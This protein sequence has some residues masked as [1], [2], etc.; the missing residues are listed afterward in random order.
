MHYLH[1]RFHAMGSPCS[2][3]LYAHDQ[4][5]ALATAHLVENEVLRL[6]HKYSRYRDD[7]VTAAL[8]VA[9]R[10]GRALA[11]DSETAALLDYAQVAWE[12]SDGLFDITSGVLRHAWSFPHGSVPTQARLDELLARVGWQH[13][14]WQQGEV[15][16]DRPGMEIDFGGFVKEYAADCAAAVAL[17]AGLQHGLVELGGD[18]R[19]IGPHPDGRPWSVGIRHPRLPGQVLATI[20]LQRG[21][22]ASSGDYERCLIHNGVRYGHILNPFTGW[23][24]QGLIAVS[25]VADHCLLAGSVATLAL[26]HGEQGLAWLE[27]GEQPWLAMTACGAVHGSLAPSVGLPGVR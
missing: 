6:E 20:S 5:A 16:F 25:S 1:H 12:Q 10:Q 8:Q 9:A 15:R 4:A 18:I 11:V 26:L 24:V 14:R 17:R 23:P 13:V 19:V 2:V 21:A 22:L 27:E 7:S 3:H